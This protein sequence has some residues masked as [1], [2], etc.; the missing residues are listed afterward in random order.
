MIIGCFKLLVKDRVLDDIADQINDLSI[1]SSSAYRRSFSSNPWTR[2]WAL[3]ELSGMLDEVL[4]LADR[5]V[6]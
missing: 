3:R 4:D 1:R 5:Y 2:Y 6:A